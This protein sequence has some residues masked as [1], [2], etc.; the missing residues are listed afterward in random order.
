MNRSTIT[1]F[2]TLLFSSSVMAEQMVVI[3]NPKN[4]A[5]SITKERITSYYLGEEKS[6][7]GGLPVRLLDLP[8]DNAERATF[9]KEV[10][11]K[12]IQ[13]LKDVWSQNALSGKASP[14]KELASDA[15]VKKAVSES[16]AAIGYIKASSVDDTVKVALTL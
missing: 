11:G 4:E 2:A 12:S 15:D 8:A 10:L 16:K 7:I 13:Q 9:T 14:P 5:K 6:W 1:L 3:V